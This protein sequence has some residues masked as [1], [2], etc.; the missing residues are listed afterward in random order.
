MSF[1]V[2]SSNTAFDV[3]QTNLIMFFKILFLLLQIH[4]D[5]SMFN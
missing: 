3:S 2:H 4:L 5:I 1:H